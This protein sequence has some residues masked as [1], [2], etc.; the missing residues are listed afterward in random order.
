MIRVLKGLISAK[1]YF[2][3]FM[4]KMGDEDLINDAAVW[5]VSTVFVQ[6]PNQNSIINR[7]IVL[8]IGGY[9]LPKCV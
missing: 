7:E 6:P 8:P 9:I 3:V 4:M 1:P 5:A 2:S